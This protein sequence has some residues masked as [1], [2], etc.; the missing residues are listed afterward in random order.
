MDW[1][2]LASVWTGEKESHVSISGWMHMK[3]NIIRTKT[4][5]CPVA[6][7]S[8]HGF[9][10]YDSMSTMSPAASLS[11]TCGSCNSLVSWAKSHLGRLQYLPL[12]QYSSFC[13]IGFQFATLQNMIERKK[14]TCNSDLVDGYFDETKNVRTYWSRKASV[15]CFACK[16]ADTPIIWY[17]MPARRNFQM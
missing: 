10:L 6:T 13:I 5:Q 16:Q 15:C 17:E 2:A 8:K 11:R 12:V 7:K 1:L 14:W 4:Y 9:V 3:Q